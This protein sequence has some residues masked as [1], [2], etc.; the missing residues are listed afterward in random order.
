ME[1]FHVL[2]RSILLTV[3]RSNEAAKMHSSELDGDIW[4]IPGSRYK[5]KR[6]H[7]IPLTPMVRELIVVPKNPSFIFTN[8]KKAFNTSTVSAKP[9]S[10]WTMRWRISGNWKAATP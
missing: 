7:V 5:T 4:T 6:D 2:L 1:T 9:R 3:T 10:S 8:G